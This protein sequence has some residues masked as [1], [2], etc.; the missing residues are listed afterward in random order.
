MKQWL[1]QVQKF[2]GLQQEQIDQ[3]ISME[4]EGNL[5]DTEIC[6]SCYQEM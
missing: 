1:E 2:N 3:L 5:G 4:Y 6:L